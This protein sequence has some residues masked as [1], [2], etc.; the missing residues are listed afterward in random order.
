MTNPVDAIAARL[1]DIYSAGDSLEKTEQ[2]QS[3]QTVT[4]TSTVSNVVKTDNLFT[5]RQKEEEGKLLLTY[6]LVHVWKIPAKKAAGILKNRAV[7]LEQLRFYDGKGQEVEVAD[8]L[9]DACQT[10]PS[11]KNKA[12][13]I[14]KV[15]EEIFSNVSYARVNSFNSKGPVYLVPDDSGQLER[16]IVDR[17]LAGRHDKLAIEFI[18]AKDGHRIVEDSV[19]QPTGIRLLFQSLATVLLSSGPTAIL[20]LTIQIAS[21][22]A[23]GG[24]I[25]WIIVIGIGGGALL[26]G[27]LCRWLAVR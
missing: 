24:P 20:T 13:A 1:Y 15:L 17:G 27:I 14:T 26:I 19:A 4:T 2:N 6:L 21:G 5:D 18:S 10:N 25:A 11:G 23:A 9:C 8:T 16:D 3:Q 7:Q 12:D 22:T